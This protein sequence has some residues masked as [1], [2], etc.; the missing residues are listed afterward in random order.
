MTSAGVAPPPTLTG[1]ATSLPPRCCPIVES[2][3]QR[4]LT[5]MYMCTWY[6]YMN[7]AAVHFISYLCEAVLAN[8]VFIHVYVYARRFKQV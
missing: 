5:Y 6:L 1:L 8:T 4:V 3:V 7:C 2:P